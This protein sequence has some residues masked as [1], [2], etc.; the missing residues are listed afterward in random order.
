MFPNRWQACHRRRGRFRRS[1][2]RDIKNLNFL[3]LSHFNLFIVSISTVCE[4]DSSVS[5]VSGYGV[6]DRVI[7]VRSPAEAK[8]FFL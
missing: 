2:L 7:E 1:T 6:N 8:G 5:I 4:P 3:S